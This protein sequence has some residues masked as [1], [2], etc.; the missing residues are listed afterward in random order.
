LNQLKDLAVGQAAIGADVAT[1]KDHL[2]KV[3]GKV[4]EHERRLGEMLVEVAERRNSCPLV[5]SVQ[6]TLIDHIL[7]C[8]MKGRMDVVEDFVV[9]A[10]ASENTSKTWSDHLWPI[11]LWFVGVLLAVIAILVLAHAPIFQGLFK[12]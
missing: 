6:K 2:E 7:A 8:P 4:A 11:A 5:E 9:A 12:P 3:N 10:K 1:M